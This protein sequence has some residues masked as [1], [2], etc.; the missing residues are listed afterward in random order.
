MSIKKNGNE[1]KDVTKETIPT[2]LINR[3]SKY[4]PIFGL[5]ELGNN[6]DF[7]QIPLTWQFIE[8]NQDV[9][10]NWCVNISTDEEFIKIGCS[11]KPQIILQ[12]NG[13][14][15][16]YIQFP[17]KTLDYNY[18]ACPNIDW[19]SEKT[20]HFKGGL[21]SMKYIE[22]E[23]NISYPIELYAKFS[24][25]KAGKHPTVKMEGEYFYEGRSNKMPIEGK[26]STKLGEV[27]SFYR[28]KKD[29]KREEFTGYFTACGFRGYWEDLEHLG[30]YEFNL[31][32]VK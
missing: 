23:G 2:G 16:D 25:L 29:K 9:F 18:S 28:I 15:Y 32:L 27:I 26:F 22:A 31:D 24:I 12:W 14:K 13:T 3:I 11:K 4:T 30:I 8:G 21:N 5:T 7:T 6:P 17:E 1:W 20:Y 19:A 10:E